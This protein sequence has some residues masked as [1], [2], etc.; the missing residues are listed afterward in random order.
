MLPFCVH[1]LL[2]PVGCVAVVVVLG[3]VVDVDVVVDGAGGGTHPA[4]FAMLVAYVGAEAEATK[5]VE[6]SVN[7]S[8][9]CDARLDSVEVLGAKTYTSTPLC[10]NPSAIA[11]DA[12]SCPGSGDAS[13]KIMTAAPSLRYPSPVLS[14]VF[15]TRSSAAVRLAAPPVNVAPVISETAQKASNASLK[16]HRT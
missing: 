12:A 10:C 9:G 5:V 2:A 7:Q 14:T 16:S 6:L 8:D 15:D 13:L 11:L 3:V 4:R 1:T